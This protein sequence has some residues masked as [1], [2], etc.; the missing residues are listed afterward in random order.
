[1]PSTRSR[2]L[3]FEVCTL[4]CNKNDTVLGGDFSVV[5]KE[6]RRGEFRF[7]GSL[8][9]PHVNALLANTAREIT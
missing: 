6:K 2:T 3:C 5:M 1:M 4:F 7:T 9:L 8:F